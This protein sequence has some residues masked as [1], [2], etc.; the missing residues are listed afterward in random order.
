[1]AQANPQASPR[2]VRVRD[3]LIDHRIR[4]SV[5]TCC[6]AA[7][8]GLAL[9]IRPA[10]ITDYRAPA[11][12]AGVLLALCGLSLRSWA[13]GTLRKGQ[14][15]TTTGPYRLCRHPLYLGTAL[16]LTGSAAG[17]AGPRPGLALALV[18]IW[19]TIDREERRMKVK[20]GTE[21]R[22]YVARTPRLVPARL[23]SDVGRNGAWANGCEL[24]HNAVTATLLAAGGV[25]RWQ[26]LPT[27]GQSVSGAA[28]PYFLW[29]S[30]EVI[31]LATISPPAIFS[32]SGST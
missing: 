3:F 7:G 27:P 31:F 4:L 18:V 14:A 17:A 8:L 25:Y 32:P 6:L 29:H 23:P 5:T 13:A 12:V 15:L 24:E 9:G 19:M 22:A 2:S 21:W 16:L 1:M 28:Q 20:Y 10:D 11:S 30:A 26:T